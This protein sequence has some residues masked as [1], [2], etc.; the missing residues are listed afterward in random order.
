MSLALLLWFLR[1][2]LW[3]FGVFCDSTQILGLFFLSLG[4]NHWGFDGRFVASADG[5]GLCGHFNSFNSSGP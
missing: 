1:V 3:L 2:L 5:C 4:G